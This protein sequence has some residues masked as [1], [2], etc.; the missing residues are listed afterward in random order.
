MDSECMTEDELQQAVHR[1][2]K[3]AQT[4]SEFRAICLSDPGEA[5]RQV[6]GKSLPRGFKLQF[7]DSDLGGTA[8]TAG[9]E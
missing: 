1:I 6:A 4:N 3:L 5:I 7:L 9:P 8:K 2:F